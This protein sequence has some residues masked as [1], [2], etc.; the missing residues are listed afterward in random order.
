MYN[1]Q[2][3]L[4][5]IYDLIIIMIIMSNSIVITISQENHKKLTKMKEYNKH[6]KGK[7]D[8]YDDVIKKLIE[9]KKE[10]KGGFDDIK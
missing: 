3:K 4:L 1:D 9:S 2:N 10:E 8:T 5:N 6:R 7:I